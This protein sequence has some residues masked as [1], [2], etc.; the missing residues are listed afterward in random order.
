MAFQIV[1]RSRDNQP[2]FSVGM[3]AALARVDT[4]F[5]I[6]CEHFGLLAPHVVADGTRRYTLADVRK[7]ALIYRLH[8]Q[9]ELDLDSLGVVLHLRRQVVDLQQQI[10]QKERQWAR[11]EQAMQAEIHRLRRLLANMINHDVK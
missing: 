9:L 4:A 1:I 5:L 11:K 7:A 6:G 10:E 8:Q 3:A 2:Q